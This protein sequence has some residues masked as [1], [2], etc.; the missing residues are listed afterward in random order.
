ESVTVA[1]TKPTVQ[2][3]PD[4]TVYSLTKNIQSSTS[5]LS[6]VLRNLPSIDV[7]I[8]GNVALR[9]DANVT[10]LIDGKKSPLLA[11][12]RADALQQIPAAMIDRIEV[13]TNPSA[14]F[15]AEGSGGIINIILKKDKEMVA[16]GVVRVNLGSGGRLNASAS[17]NIKL[18]H[19]NLNG[20]YG[21]VRDGR[22]GQASTLRS[23]GTNVTSSQDRANKGVYSGRYTWLY[24][25]T[26]LNEHDNVSLGGNYNRFAGHNNSLEHNVD[27]VSDITRD[28]LV[29]WQREGLGAQLQYGHK[30]ATKDE[31]VHLDLSH[32]ATW[33]RNG[34]DFTSLVT[35]TGVGTYW[36]SQS[37]IL[38]E[39][40]TEFKA[41]YTLPLPH[42]GKFKA[43]Y[44]LQNDSS[45]TNNHG[46]FRD[47]TMSVPADDPS[48]TNNFLLDRTIHAGYLS[49]QQKFG[50]FGVMAGLRL[51]QD[52]L[53][54]NLKTTGE[55]H[56]TATLGL[57]PSLHLSYA[58]T[59]TQQLMLSYS[60]RMNRP[61]TNALNPARYSNDAFN[62]W[63]GNPYLKPEQVDSFETSYRYTAEKF[64]AVITGY[65]R[66]TYKGFT[67]VY[68][69][70]NDTVLLTTMDN[71]ARRMASGVE[72]NLNAKLLSGLSLRTTGTLSYNE[73]NPTAAGLGK[74]QSGLGWT[75]KGGLDWQP[76]PED[77]VQFNTNYASKQRF[78][79]GYTQPTLYGDLG[80]KHSFEGGLAA[81]MSLNNLYASAHR[82]TVLDSPGL[83][84]VDH[85][86][87]RGR[88]LFLGLVYTFGGFR[89]TQPTTGGGTDAAP[90]GGPPG[91]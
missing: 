14:E 46:L 73:F 6:D 18:G 82:D 81:V 15:R 36:Q 78:S 42:E 5:S 44:A 76:T 62:V 64:D 89:D 79:Q 38:R 30:F 53:N 70:L 65:Y 88:V 77:H 22:K 75:L 63:A 9:G 69:Y 39:G 85:R 26:D 41:D 29:V 11:G 43:G 10:I 58:L 21:E 7:D 68:R 37:S 19:I 34:T 2:V 84:Q 74:K 66:A 33:G 35:A 49:Y 86:T 52:Y 83:H 71:L 56:D 23:D 87:T 55:I 54:T 40:H 50:A 48:F 8:E 17:G 60:R 1:A 32:Y 16:A 72:A 51:E 67:S 28:G 3:L 80:Y 59:D 45:Q 25:S 90:P 47:A 4:R 31:E 27:A 12:N 57:Y 91:Q 24:A 13:I 20:G 61:A